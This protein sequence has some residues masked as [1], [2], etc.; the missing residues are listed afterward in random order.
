MELLIFSYQHASA[1]YADTGTSTDNTF[2]AAEVFPSPTPTI[3]PTPSETPTPTPSLSPTVTPTPSE[4]PTPTPTIGVFLNEFMP[5]P[6]GV[7]DG[8]EWVELV[9]LSGSTVDLTNWK[10]ED[11]APTPNVINIGSESIL[12]GDY[13]LYFF[14]SASLNNSGGDTL[15]L[16]NDSGV[17]VDSIAY[18][19][20]PFP[21]D[22]TFG[23]SVDGAGIW[24]VCTVSSQDTS[25][26]GVC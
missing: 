17:V 7:E 15:F 22:S 20:S 10:I 14:S 9:N 13:N 19:G 2:T 5:N 25:N 1:L 23:R 12:T 16:K 24:K 4:T 26:N 21:E 6:S 8:A 11:A 3:T 18:A